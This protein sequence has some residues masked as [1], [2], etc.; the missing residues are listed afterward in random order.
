VKLETWML[1]KAR[2]AFAT[3][4]SAA[5]LAGDGFGK[6]MGI[7]NGALQAHPQDQQPTNPTVPIGWTGCGLRYRFLQSSASSFPNS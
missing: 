4:I 2:R 6:P 3:Q 7:L 5:V 1:D